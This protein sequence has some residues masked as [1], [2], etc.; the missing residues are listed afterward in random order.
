MLSNEELD[1]MGERLRAAVLEV[2]P[3]DL[4][5]L[6]VSVLLGHTY[7]RGLAVAYT[8]DSETAKKIHDMVW[9]AYEHDCPFIA[10]RRARLDA[11]GSDGEQPE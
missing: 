3:D 6:D 4:T 5:N 8:D 2:L 1:A 9:E 11:E 10:E 7:A